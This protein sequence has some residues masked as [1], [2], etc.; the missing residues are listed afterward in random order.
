MN[1]FIAKPYKLINTIQNYE[2]GTK[3]SE[4]FIPGFLGIEPE[5]D[6]TY[7]ELW[8][9]AHPK[10]P[11]KVV[12]EGKET[13]LDKLVDNFPKE[14]LGENTAEKFE[15]KLPFLLKVL[16]AGKAL[17]IQTHPDK[18]QAEYLH[19]KDPANYPDDNHKPEIAIAVDYLNAIVG[20]KP[21]EEIKKIFNEYPEITDLIGKEL[22]EDFISNG[23][24]ASLK[25]MYSD[26][27]KSSEDKIEPVILS[28][29]DKIEKKTTV[30]DYEKQFL[31]E[32]NEYGIDVGLFSILIF[33]Y[34]KL[35]AD[36]GIFTDAGVPH[37][38]L[39]GNIIECMANSD[40]VVRAGLTP[41][42]KDVETLSEILDYSTKVPEIL[43]ERKDNI[44]NYSTSAKEFK[45]SVIS[46]DTEYRDNILTDSVKIYL[47][48][49]GKINITAGDSCYEFF[50]G[51]TV[52]VP[53]AI[54]KYELLL[55][56]NSKVFQV[57]VP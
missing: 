27:L 57:I 48:S 10:A 39:K 18:S 28:I 41:K 50:K 5:P 49:E 22:C 20:F 1:N 16:S 52:L 35:E 36:Q 23:S 3:N 45:L 32:L 56:A 4:A 40:N 15:S 9:G 13:T 34:V 11:S 17:S 47:V 44:V 30:T 46:S 7:A 53:A 8:I 25:K 6:Q 42:F 43:G 37:A 31:N 19:K 38:Y 12:Y 2:W 14:I 26:L 51:E 54:D 33:N 21:V 24:V 55:K 29:K